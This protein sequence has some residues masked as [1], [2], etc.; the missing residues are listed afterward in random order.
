MAAPA[1]TSAL[2]VQRIQSTPDVGAQEQNSKAWV[3]EFILA[4]GTVQPRLAADVDKL[5][6]ELEKEGY[7]TLQ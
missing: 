2:R 3:R 5:M 1:L 7:D 6:V 4:C